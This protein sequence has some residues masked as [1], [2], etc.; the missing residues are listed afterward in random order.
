VITDM[1]QQAVNEIVALHQF[2]QQWYRGELSAD[3]FDR[4]EQALDAEFLIITPDGNVLSRAR[5]LDA[6]RL[7]AGTDTSVSLEIRNVETVVVDDSVAVFRY[8]EWQSSASD[9]PR[10]RLSTVIFRRQHTGDN[11]LSW[12]QVHET[13]LPE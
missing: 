3:A 8:E 11:G 4:F 2:F 12:L 6:V 1:K 9:A 13:W 10:G 7:Q 5:I